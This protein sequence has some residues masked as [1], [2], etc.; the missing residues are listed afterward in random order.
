MRILYFT[1]DYTVHD[2]RFLTALAATDHEMYYMALE[3]LEYHREQRALPPEIK[4][5][6]WSGGRKPF[7]WLITPSLLFDLKKVLSLLKPDLIHAGPIQT[8]AFLSALS[9]FHPLI[10]MSWGYD[11]LHDAD[12]NL[13]TR[14]ITR[15]CLRKSDVLVGDCDSVRQKAIAFGM[16]DERIVTFPWGVDLQKFRASGAI[17]N[18][19]N[20]F[21]LLS[22]RGWEP[23]Y[24]VEIIAKA[25]VLAYQQHPELRLV[26]LGNG[27][28]T[29]R[30]HQIFL[31][32]GISD[33]VSFPGQV[34]QNDLPNYYNSADL[35]V[36]ASRI[37]GT[38]ISARPHVLR[39]FCH[40]ARTS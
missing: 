30:I 26:M 20:S 29:D 19:N 32:G 22:T 4:P 36:S 2:R 24:G 11:L 40:P 6:E 33:Q 12:R 37:D 15:Y 21:T 38:S 25:F 27:S 8:S 17:P 31:E 1:R 34:G 14:W 3:R 13:M 7:H 35:Y 18:S 16:P 39:S 10:S 5:I 28:Q 9:G 23:I